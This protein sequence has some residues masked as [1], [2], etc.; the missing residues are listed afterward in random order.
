MLTSRYI[1]YCQLR[2][3]SCLIQVILFGEKRFFARIS[4]VKIRLLYKPKGLQPFIY[5]TKIFF[6][7]SIKALLNIKLS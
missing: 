7:F 2:D 5:M 1:S 4:E 6:Y 3:K